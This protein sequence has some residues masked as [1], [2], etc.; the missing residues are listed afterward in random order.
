MNINYA[1]LKEKMKACGHLVSE[2]LQFTVEDLAKFRDYAH[3]TLGKDARTALYEM[4]FGYTD[5]P[6]VKV[7]TEAPVV[8][9]EPEP[10]PVVVAEPVE[11]LAEAKEAEPEAESK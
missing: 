8:V 10:E 11:P 1:E 5:K 6:T 7:T 4:A 2:G 3:F 9:T